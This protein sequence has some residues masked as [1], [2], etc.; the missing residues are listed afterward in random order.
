MCCIIII[1]RGNCDPEVLQEM[2]K[3]YPKPHFLPE[4]CEFPSKEYVFMGYEAGATM[5]VSVQLAN[6]KQLLNISYNFS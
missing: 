4:D 2:R 1:F 6:S 5:H 3:Y